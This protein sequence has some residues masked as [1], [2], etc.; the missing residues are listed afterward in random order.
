MTAAQP[1]VALSAQPA[2]AR[3]GQHRAGADPSIAARPSKVATSR[4]ADVVRAS[5]IRPNSPVRGGRQAGLDAHPAEAERGKQHLAASGVAAPAG[6]PERVRL[7]PRV[8]PT[9]AVPI[10]AP[11]VER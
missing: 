2:P 4:G 1:L 8:A 5:A 6:D 3:R 7:S 10:A 11:M 9:A